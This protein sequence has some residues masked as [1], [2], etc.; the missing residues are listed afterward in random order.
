MPG[1]IAFSPTYSKTMFSRS[2]PLNLSKV[3][4]PASFSPTYSN[5]MFF[6]SM[7]NLSKVAR[8]AR[9]SSCRSGI[10]PANATGRLS[11]LSAPRR[12]GAGLRRR[13]PRPGQRPPRLT[14]RPR[15]S[16]PPSMPAWHRSPQGAPRRPPCSPG[17]SRRTHWRRT[18]ASDICSRPCWRPSYTQSAPPA[19]TRRRSEWRRRRPEPGPALPEYIP[20]NAASYRQRFQAARAIGMPA[21]RAKVR[22]EPVPP[23][24]QYDEATQHYVPP[25]VRL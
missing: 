12:K 15:V 9:L 5:T 3:A 10:T 23:G 16:K 22:G 2:M 8:P 1:L 20:G 4:R 18:P 21:Y 17:C 7:P 24:W 14:Q 19:P 25:H 11:R 13:R 6:R